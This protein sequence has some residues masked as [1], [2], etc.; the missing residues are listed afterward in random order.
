MAHGIKFTPATGR[1]ATE[2]L[3]DLFDDHQQICVA[4]E[5]LSDDRCSICNCPGEP[6]KR[7]RCPGGQW[8]D[9]EYQ[10]IRARLQPQRIDPA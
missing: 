6:W 4:C 2:E 8:W 3:Q 5:F 9:Q 7:P 1:T 10:Q